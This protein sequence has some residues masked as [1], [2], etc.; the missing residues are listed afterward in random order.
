MRRLTLYISLLWTLVVQAAVYTPTEVPSPKAQGKDYYVA[1]PDDIIAD[2]DVDFLNRCAAMLEQQTQVELCVVALESIGDVDCFDFSY[3][4]YQRWGLG[5]KGKNTGVL[6]VFVLSSHDIR[7]MTGTGIEGVLTDAQCAQVIREYMAPLFREGDYGGGLCRGALRIY[8]I[9]TDG[10]APEELQNAS[11]VTNRGQYGEDENNDNAW[12][13]GI[14]LLIIL[15]A[16]IYLIWHSKGNGG[17]SNYSGG[18]STYYGG[19]F[20]GGG[21]SGGGFSGGGFSGGSWGG[22]STSGGGAGGKW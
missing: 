11:S 19:G 14:I 15:I 10:E 5:K 13:Y 20:S 22:G 8:E 1:N 7:I 18:R 4:L 2:E 6:I 16:I 21:F 17:G 9:C 12:V 3:E